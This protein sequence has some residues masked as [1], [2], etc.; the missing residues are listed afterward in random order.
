[1]PARVQNSTIGNEENQ[2]VGLER[3]TGV[4]PATLSLGKRIGRFVGA[5]RHSQAVARI[6]ASRSGELHSVS[7]GTRFCRSGAGPVLQ[8]F[9]S[10]RDVAAQLRVSTA[11]VYKLCAARELP[12]VRVL[13]AIRIAPDDLAAFVERLRRATSTG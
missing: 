3:E 8:G 12:H 2:G 11:T 10:V 13:G 4:E 1:M 7:F 6:G 5:C 9:L